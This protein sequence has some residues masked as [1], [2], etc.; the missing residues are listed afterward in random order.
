MAVCVW[1][2][3]GSARLGSARLVWLEPTR[4]L[5][6]L[7]LARI[8]WSRKNCKSWLELGPYLEA[9]LVT[10]AKPCHV[11]HF[12]ARLVTDKEDHVANCDVLTIAPHFFFSVISSLRGF[13]RMALLHVPFKT[14][15]LQSPRRALREQSAVVRADIAR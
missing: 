8:G 14:F 12:C 4:W 2:G 15:L 5:A 10:V 6:R 7:E 1:L 3:P 11:L 9:N 13:L